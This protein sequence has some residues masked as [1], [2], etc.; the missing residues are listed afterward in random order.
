MIDKIKKITDDGDYVR[1]VDAITKK[2]DD[3]I[4]LLEG[5]LAKL[6]RSTNGYPF[7]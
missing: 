1:R 3:K 6:D 4:K 2:L 5:R 7:K